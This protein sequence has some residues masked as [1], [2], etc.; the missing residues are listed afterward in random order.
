MNN[1]VAAANDSSRVVED[2]KLAK[3]KSKHGDSILFVIEKS[4]NRNCVVYRSNLGF[5]FVLRGHSWCREEGQLSDYKSIMTSVAD[6]SGK[7]DPCKP[8]D[9]HW[10]MQE[11]EGGTKTSIAFCPFK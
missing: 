7:L 10:I 2:E 8:I 5:L 11:Q 6:Q 3:L 1:S 4:V 9:V